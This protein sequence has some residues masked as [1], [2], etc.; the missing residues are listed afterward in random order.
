[1]NNQEVFNMA[2]RGLAWQGFRRSV[3]PSGRCQYRG[4][5]GRKC[6]IGHCIPDEEYMPE[7]EGKSISSEVMTTVRTR[8]FAGADLPFLAALQAAH[9]SPFSGV[10]PED[11]RSTLSDVAKRYNLTWP[12]DVP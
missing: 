2:V 8:L 1:M 5:G 9:D 7:M 10:T 12:E 3:S 4:G 11:L 6:A